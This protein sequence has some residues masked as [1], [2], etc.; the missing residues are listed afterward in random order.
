MFRS[1][2]ARAA[3]CLFAAIATTCLAPA[4]AAP[5]TPAEIPIEAFFSNSPFAGAVLS[6]NAKFLAVRISPKDRR[7]GL[8]VI[9][10]TT[11]QGKV[12]AQFSDGDISEFRWV[13]DERLVFSLGDTT[14][15]QRDVKEGPGLYAV[16]R[17]GSGMRQLVAQGKEYYDAKI[18]SGKNLLHPAHYLHGQRG[19]QN[20]EYVYVTRPQWDGS[21]EVR[22]VELL[23]LNTLTGTVKSVTRPPNVMGWLLDFKGEPRVAV[24]RTKNQTTV[25]Y[26]ETV[27]SEWSAI[28][29]GDLF[30]IKDSSFAPL[31]FGPNNTLY[32]QTNNGLGD[33]EEIYLYN[34]KTNKLADKPL[35][36]TPGYDFSGSLITNDEKVLGMNFTTDATSTMW[37][38]PKMKALQ[39]RID[40]LL[41]PTIN[42]LSVSQR[43]E[44]PW[45]LVASYSDVQPVVYQLFNVVTGAFQ[46][47]GESRPDIDPSLMA[48]QQ[49]ITLKARDGM[50]IPALLTLPKGKSKNLPLVVLVHGGPQIRGSVWGWGRETQFLASRGY[51]VIEPSFRGT[52]GFGTKHFRS[53]WKQ[54]GLASQDDIADSALWAIEKGIADGNRVCIAGASYGGYATLMGLIKHHDLYK[55]GVNWVGVSDIELL[56]KGHWSFK[57]D[58]NDQWRDYGMPDMIGDIKKDAEQLKATSPLVQASRLKRPL[59]MAY[60][61]AD[62]RVPLYHG[63]KMAAALKGINNDV[64]MIVYPEE[65]HGWAL[66]KN[67]YD[68]YGRMVKFLDK[69]IGDKK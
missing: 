36:S 39:D 52:T 12:V 18:G 65:G 6:P 45:V 31:A 8:Y 16:N 40:D 62:R 20:S 28:S 64:E 23:R 21:G 54:W 15:G 67:N 11:N 24:G 1:T 68:F 48:S 44:T 14:V 57:S 51:A 30:G 47:I 56:T 17:D 59:M 19:L 5:A 32:V 69:H 27:D 46:K 42:L 41:K 55:C 2:A 60:G 58:M 9:D 7:Y 38:D 61:A 3:A 66:P 4:Y 10:L 26:R 33:K 37:F 13:N 29:S 50:D 25:Y 22:Y 63:E 34:Y 43:P 53:G 35:I 49:Q